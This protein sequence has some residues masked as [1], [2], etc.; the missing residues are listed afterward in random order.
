L[1]V[2]G[3]TDVS[4][5][6]CIAGLKGKCLNAITC[7]IAA[8]RISPFAEEGVLQD[9]GARHQ[10]EIIGIVNLDTRPRRPYRSLKAKVW[11]ARC[12]EESSEDQ[13]KDDT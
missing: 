11:E 10:M 13:E 6:E 7:S 8:L 3:V 5:R 2:T 4:D 12:D 9:E 1:L